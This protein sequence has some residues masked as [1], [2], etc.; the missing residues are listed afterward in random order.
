M[1]EQNFKDAKSSLAFSQSLIDRMRQEK[2]EEQ[3]MDE[4]T[5]EEVPKEIEEVKEPERA[6]EKP[7][8]VNN[9]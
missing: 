9:A 5:M 1:S 3:I 8:E 2:A 6:I 7:E 4:D